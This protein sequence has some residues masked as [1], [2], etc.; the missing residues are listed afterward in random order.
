M[1]AAS[2]TAAAT[3]GVSMKEIMSRAGW[4]NEHTF[5]KFYYRPR[6]MADYGETILQ[7]CKE[8]C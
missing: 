6:A 5:T 1:R 3:S 8:I 4:S 7:T 2:A